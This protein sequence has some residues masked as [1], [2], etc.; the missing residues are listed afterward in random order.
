[1]IKNRNKYRTD[2]DKKSGKSLLLL[3]TSTSSIQIIFMEHNI[4][5]NVLRN[6][7]GK[8]YKRAT[9]NGICVGSYCKQTPQYY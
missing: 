1:M 7:R 2:D 9:A 8:T 6:D 4:M 3:G 5:I